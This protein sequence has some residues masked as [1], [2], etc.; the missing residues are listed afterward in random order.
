LAAFVLTVVERAVTFI[1]DDRLLTQY[2]FRSLS[3]EQTERLDQ[4]SVVDDDFAARL[5][6]VENDLVDAYVRGE[7]PAEEASRFKSAYLSSPRRRE[8]VRFA[9]TLVSLEQRAAN[10]PVV[11]RPE[12][13]RAENKRERAGKR[14]FGNWFGT[15]RRAS[16]WF[17][18][19]W[20]L[21][22]AVF[23]L[24]VASGY[25]L[26]SNRELRQ[27]VKKAESDRATLVQQQG[28]LQRQ[29]AIMA[30][31]N[32]ANQGTHDKS[33]LSLDHLRV[34]AFTLGPSLRG[35][36]ELPTVSWSA[37][38][39]LVV[40]KLELESSEFSNYRVTIQD[41][42]SR[43][44]AWQND[45]LEPAY[46]GNRRV[47]SIALPPSVLKSSNYVVQLEGVRANG[48]TELVSSYP[49]RGVVK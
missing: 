14:F 13:G 38:T 15:S 27:E 32:P 28:Q 11:A 22:G 43:H 6:A 35:A 31:A 49:F 34:A 41:S 47:L 4:L 36:V 46:E 10:K 12:A 7:L 42:S 18:A 40:L 26:N 20:G 29:V 17:A 23:L 24:L 39:D 21:A 48:A 1:P 30:A 16:T 9:A 19:Q 8:K 25:L 44:A 37:N 33:P 45:A 3:E 2:L 5:N